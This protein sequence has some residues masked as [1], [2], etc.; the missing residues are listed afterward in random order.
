MN[1]TKYGIQNC[2]FYLHDKREQIKDKSKRR[3]STLIIA[4]NILFSKDN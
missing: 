2:L 1:P 3:L 4:T